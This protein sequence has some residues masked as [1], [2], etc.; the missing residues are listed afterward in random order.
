ME[1]TIGIFIERLDSGFII[2]QDLKA[3]AIEKTVDTEVYLINQLKSAVNRFMTGQ[4]KTMNVRISVE[5]NPP[6][7]K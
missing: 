6:T 5:E 7:N 1:K 2:T 3:R 4:V